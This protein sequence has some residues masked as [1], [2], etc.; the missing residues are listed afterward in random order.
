MLAIEQGRRRRIATIAAAG[1]TDNQLGGI[2]VAP[3]DTLYLARLGHGHAGAIF[4]IAGGAVTELPG[5]SPQAWRLGVAYDAAEH[6]L[7]ATRYH[8]I[9]TMPCDGSIER[10]DLA[11]GEVVSAIEGLGKPVGVVKLGSTLVI[12]DARRGAVLRAELVGG[13]AER[14]TELATGIDRPDSIAAC[15]IVPDLGDRMHERRFASLVPGPEPSA[16]HWEIRHAR[17]R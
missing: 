10:I 5:L 15:G 17:V 16:W 9:S 4:Q 7:Y 11:T 14:C 1:C 2:T 12:S 6:A 8:K 3:D 13:R